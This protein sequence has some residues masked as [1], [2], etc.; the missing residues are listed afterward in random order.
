[1]LLPAIHTLSVAP[2]RHL[3]ACEHITRQALW[4]ESPLLSVLQQCQVHVRWLLARYL[5]LAPDRRDSQ[6]APRQ[7]VARRLCAEVS[8]E[9][10][11]EEAVF[12]SSLDE[13]RRSV[14]AAEAGTRRFLVRG[15]LDRVSDIRPGTALF[16][17]RVLALGRAFE[18][19]LHHTMLQAA[20][21]AW[22]AEGASLGVALRD[23]RESILKRIANAD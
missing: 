23:R 14:T 1:M 22:R 7:G 18:R 15:M 13:A 11:A 20:P 21:V 19:H 9:I 3:L 4:H 2:A 17:A 8:A 12:D 5:L 16:D 6:A 10:D